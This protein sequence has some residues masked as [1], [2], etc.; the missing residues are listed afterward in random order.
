[1]RANRIKRPK[2]PRANKPNKYRGSVARRK[3]G[4]PIIKPLI[5][6]LWSIMKMVF[7]GALA[8]TVLMFLSIGL[9]LGYQYLIH[10]PYFMVRKVVIEGIDRV[11]RQ[12]VLS[13]TGLD[14]PTNMLT[15]RLEKMGMNLRKASWIDEVTLTRKLPDTIYIQVTERE[16]KALISLGALYYLD[17][18][19]KPFKKVDS[20]ENPEMPIITGF[21]WDDV[22]KRERF[23]RKDLNDVF[24]LMGI[25]RERNDSFR[26]DNISE[27]NFDPARGLSLFTREDNVQ[28]RIGFKNYRAKLTRLGRVIALL[29]IRGESEN[30]VYFNLVSS[31]RVIVRRAANS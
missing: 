22:V 18:K 11:P 2:R 28:V 23:T 1:M 13:K 19:G 25:L 3:S 9:I 6:G 27:I 8:L 7:G 20:K 12:E 15:L 24:T 31:P 5:L 30:M 29:K 17:A 16:P 10:S 21:T 14:K 26:L 4:K